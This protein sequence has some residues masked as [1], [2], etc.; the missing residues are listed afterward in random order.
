MKISYR[1]L[2]LLFLTTFLLTLLNGVHF[3]PDSS[4]PI[5]ILPLEQ[6]AAAK[7]SGGRSGGGS[8]RGSS[9]SRSRSSGSSGSR[10]RSS[11]PSSPSY[12]NDNY[13]R[14]DRYY[15]NDPYYHRN[16]SSTVYYGAPSPFM[17]F[18]IMAIFLGIGGLILFSIV[19]SLLKGVTKNVSHE[20]QED[21]VLNN[22]TF[23][24]SKVQVA[25]LA[26]AKDVQ[27]SLSEISLTTDTETPEGLRELY[28]ESILTLLR[29]QEDWTHVNATSRRVSLEQAEAVFGEFSLTEREKFNTETLSN[30]DGILRQKEVKLSEDESACYVV[31]TLI[32]GTAHD[33]PLFKEIRQKEELKEVLKQLAL[34]PKDYLMKFE[35]LWSPQT[36]EDT[37]TYD[38]FVLE[39]TDMINLG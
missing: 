24:I 10:S 21:R 11:S 33:H 2:S 23:A 27:L 22:N 34:I 29:H 1:P 20:S 25:L 32:I 36:P 5:S 35:L 31:V 7:S 14:N 17:S 18:L 4:N 9:G 8:F 3:T 39:Y 15:H 37:M 26:Y 28:N 6:P 38:E 13:Y 19:Y 12:R 16:R 30:M